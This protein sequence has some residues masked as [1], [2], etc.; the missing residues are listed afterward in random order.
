[1]IVISVVVQPQ[2]LFSLYELFPMAGFQDEIEINDTMEFF[3]GSF[4]R[5]YHFK[6]V[7]Q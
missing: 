4:A 2:E 6:H 3:I 7:M 1:M 5:V